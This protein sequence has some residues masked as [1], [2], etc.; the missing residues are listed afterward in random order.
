[1]GVNV[2]LIVHF[3]P[4]PSEVP[5]LFVWEKFPVVVTLEI[6]SACVPVFVRVTSFAGLVV[7]TT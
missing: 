2:T 3:F 6:V 1:V 7:P 4:A 5:Q